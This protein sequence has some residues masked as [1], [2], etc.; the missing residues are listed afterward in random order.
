MNVWP[1]TKALPTSKQILT[2]ELLTRKLEFTPSMTP[3]EVTR[4][5]VDP[6]LSRLYRGYARGQWEREEHPCSI[7]ATPIYA[8]ETAVGAHCF[9]TR[10]PTVLLLYLQGE[11]MTNELTAW[12]TRFLGKEKISIEAD[13]SRNQILLYGF[14]T[15]AVDNQLTPS[16]ALPPFGLRHEFLLNSKAITKTAQ[17]SIMSLGH[18]SIGLGTTS[19]VMNALFK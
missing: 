15:L 1:T 4:L 18:E 2:Y 17:H 3:I 6:S 19:T 14:D 16:A 9:I 7:S 12:G 8:P 13:V 11:S 5:R 10:P